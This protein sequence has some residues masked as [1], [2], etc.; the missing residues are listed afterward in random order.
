MDPLANHS[1]PP[2]DEAAWPTSG[3]CGPRW[4]VEMR[5]RL[6][7]RFAAWFDRLDFTW[8]YE[9]CAFATEHDQYLPDFRL[10]TRSGAT[11]YVETKGPLI[12]DPALMQ[13]RMEVIWASD[14]AARL[15]LLDAHGQWWFGADGR[16]K[17]SD[18]F[19]EAA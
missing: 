19:G 5:S 10:T 11:W 6:E 18:D 17:T 13:R 14:P 9:P 7:A 3:G 15:V 16:W 2:A 4:S 1:Q 8:E 12:I